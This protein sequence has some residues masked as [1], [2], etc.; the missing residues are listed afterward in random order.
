MYNKK[1]NNNIKERTKQREREKINWT[2]KNEYIIEHK[3]ERKK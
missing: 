3:R 1:T 2:T